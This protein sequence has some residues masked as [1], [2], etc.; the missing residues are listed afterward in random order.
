MPQAGLD[1]GKTRFGCS[2]TLAWFLRPLSADTFLW[3]GVLCNGSRVVS[4]TQLHAACFVWLG[5]SPGRSGFGPSFCSSRRPGIRAFSHPEGGDCGPVLLGLRL[6]E[7]PHTQV[8]LPQLSAR[9]AGARRR[10]QGL[11]WKQSGDSTPRPTAAL[12]RSSPASLAALRPLEPTDVNATEAWP[13]EGQREV[14]CASSSSL[15]A[16]VGDPAPLG[17]SPLSHHQ[18]PGARPGPGR[19]SVGVGS[20]H[21]LCLFLQKK[22]TRVTRRDRVPWKRPGR[23]PARAL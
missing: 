5:W 6:G 11:F 22:F 8:F 9:R 3:E 21:G 1:S 7:C 16:G 2:D 12:M 23:T 15:R 14:L 20:H 13:C 17:D 19:E 10:E 4:S 18:F